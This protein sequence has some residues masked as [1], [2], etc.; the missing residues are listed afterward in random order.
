MA[1]GLPFAKKNS[2]ICIFPLPLGLAKPIK[3][4]FLAAHSTSQRWHDWQTAILL[5]Q[6]QAL[7]QDSIFLSYA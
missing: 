4:V 1:M 3:C 6:K 7:A 5:L 2:M